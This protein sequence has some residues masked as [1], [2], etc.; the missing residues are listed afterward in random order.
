MLKRILILFALLALPLSAQAQVMVSDD[1]VESGEDVTWTADNTYVLTEF[2]Y[3]EQGASLTIEPGT[4]IKGQPG[5]GDDASALIIAQD[6]QVFAEGTP[7]NPIIFTSTADTDAF[8]DVEQERGEWGG[9]LL[10]GNA[11]ITVEGGDEAN[12][13]GIPASEP[14]GAY[15]GSDPADDS[16]VFRYVSIRNGGSLIGA[17]NEINGLTMGGV[18][19]GTTIEF[20]EVYNNLDDCFEWFGGTV[21]TKHLV[22][23]F[24][25]DDTFDYD[26]GFRGKGQ[27]WFGLMD[28]DAGNRSGEHDGGQPDGNTPTSIPTVYN[29]TYI[30]SGS[31]SSQSEN[32]LAFFFRDNAGGKYY[33]SVFTDYFNRGIQIEDLDGG[34]DSRERL[35]EGDLEL[36]NNIW[37]DFGAGNAISAWAAD[38]T[39]DDGATVSQQFVRD[40]LSA[41]AN[42]NY[43]ESPELRGISRDQDGGLDPRP[44]SGSPALANDRQS[45]PDGDDFFREVDYLGAFGGD[46]L[47]LS[48]WSYLSQS[49]VLTQQGENEV[50]VSDGDVESGED[51]TWTADNTY[52]LTE[53]VYVEQGA[54]LTIEPGTVIKGQ[55]GAGDDASALIIAQDGQVFAEGTPTNPIIFTSTADTDAFDD[56]EQE[57]GEWG[58]VLLLGNAPITVEGGDEANIEGIPAS[59]PRGAYG[60]SD[61]A[62]DSGVFRYV[63]IRNGGSLIGANNEI[64]GLT[65]GGVGTGTTI[66]FVEVYNNL[67]DCFEW[68]GGTVNTKH[69]V[70][71]FC[72]DDTFDYDQG[73][74]GKGQFWFGLMDEDAGNRSGEHDGGQPDGNTPTSIPTVYN[75]T[76]I[77]SG[78]ESSQS[79]NDLA[80]FFRDNAGGKYYNSVFTDYFNR[81][82]QIEDLD[83]GADSRERLAEGD[84]ELQNNIWYDFGAGN[85]ISAWAADYTDD[86]GATVSQQFVRD[87]LSASA[88]ANYVESPELRGISRDQDGGLDPRPSSGSPAL[89]NDRQSYPDGDDFFREVDYIGAFGSGQSNWAADW[90]FLGASGVLTSAGATNPKGTAIQPAPGAPVPQE[91]ALEGNFPNPVRSQTTIAF[92]LDETKHVRLA[93]YD[94][95]GR[96][97]ATLVDAVKPAGEYEA[98]FD[99]TGLAAGTYLI[100]L[101]A[102]TGAATETMTLVE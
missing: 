19:T 29:A 70:G 42:A 13:E 94:V 93:V 33:N 55:P 68:F 101:R 15:G 12:I 58:G 79:E 20:V 66:E 91:V 27:F 80:F 45:Y 54:S 87:Y 99:A 67:D 31:E 24:C 48:G 10:L 60:G 44:S 1:D 76:Y 38:Y 95:M 17:N 23:G 11:P 59:E 49:G 18:G 53:F 90:T 61:P 77:G 36:Q 69:L 85:A 65:M 63:S 82:I 30:G 92:G 26:Q 84:L 5:A 50:M 98:Q 74:R 83:G 28:E 86:D 81:G 89:A 75:A 22:G 52:V 32:D 40:Y 47:W 8:D 62:D 6:G 100:R 16:G 96:R 72:G 34:A 56:V 25:G 102:G 2:V 71:G 7:T 3:V 46:N 57:R 39:D 37:Y 35:A 64:N 88:N 41:S 14:R 51:V 4:V 78:S 73:F 43:V 21:N 97:V 9:V